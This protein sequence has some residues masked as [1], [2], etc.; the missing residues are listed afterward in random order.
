MTEDIVNKL[1]DRLFWSDA[2]EAIDEIKR[3]RKM[4]SDWEETAKIL[5]LDLGH[6][7]YANEVYD[8]IQSGLYEKVR[9]RLKDSKN[10]NA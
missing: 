1:K 9:G 10:K 7:E 8:D 5:A 2:E 4:V 3:L 6:P